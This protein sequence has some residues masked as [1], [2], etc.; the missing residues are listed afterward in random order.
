MRKDAE[1]NKPLWEALAKVHEKSQFYDLAGFKKSGNSLPEIDL[2]ILGDI[3]DE[4]ILHLQ[5][6][7]G[8]ES[9]SLANRGAL[10]T[11]IDFSGY[12]IQVARHLAASMQI[13]VDFIHS[14]VYE[15]DRL[16]SLPKFDKI[17]SSY[18]VIPWLYD[19]KLWAK[20]IYNQLA[21]GGQFI[22]VEFHP[23][24]FTFDEPGKIIYDYGSMEKPEVFAMHN[25]YTGDP[26]DQAYAEYTWNH[27][28]SQ[29]IQSLLNAQLTLRDYQEYDYSP[30]PCFNEMVEYETGR[31]RLKALENIKFPYVFS[32]IFDK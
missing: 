30:Q 22:L 32:M 1:L 24:M 2:E 15:M 23:I 3:S 6:H 25:S 10:V 4:R 29:I 20:M 5:C 27:S 12:A 16:A 14:N 17:Y 21:E 28:V 26:L 18:G 7:I 9:I 13:D 11:A 19:L 8:M 31:Y